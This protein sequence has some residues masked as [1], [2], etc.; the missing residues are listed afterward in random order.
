MALGIFMFLNK[1]NFVNVNDRII[2]HTGTG[3]MVHI[4]LKRARSFRRT[5]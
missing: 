5:C 1:I 4:V 2:K 3:N